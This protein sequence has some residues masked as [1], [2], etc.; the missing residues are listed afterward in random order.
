MR[1]PKCVQDENDRF[2]PILLTSEIH[3]M[4]QPP[5]LDM[6]ALALSVKNKKSTLP[7]EYPD[8]DVFWCVNFNRFHQDFRDELMISTIKRRIDEPAGQLMK[9]LLE[10]MYIRTEPWVTTSNPIPYSEL[11]ETIRRTNGGG[12]PELVQ[13]LDQYLSLIGNR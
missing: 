3:E 6:T 1:C 12:H 8:S 4:Y 13:N 9:Y 7:K 11:K 5:K 10:L 2:I